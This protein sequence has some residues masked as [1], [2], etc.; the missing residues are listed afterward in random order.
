MAGF[1]ALP[2]FLNLK[3]R[4]V[5]L[6]GGSTAALWKAELA[7]AAGADVDVYS[8]EPCAG[9]VDLARGRPSVR[10]VRRAFQADDLNGAALAIGDIE[11]AAEAAEFRAAARAF[12]AL[13]NI[14]DKPALSDFQFG[15]IVDRSPLVVAISTDGASPILAQAVRGRIRGRAARRNQTLGGGRQ[16]LARVVEDSRSGAKVAPP[17]LG[18]VQ[19]QGPRRRLGASRATGSLRS[20]WPRSSGIRARKAPSRWSARGR[21]IPNF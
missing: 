9:L 1:A 4:R 6:A 18:D 15:A 2:V 13:A 11:G 17:L 5:A 20:Y 19:R 3:G 16:R 8:A 12:G 21:A 7:Q 14:I 10:L